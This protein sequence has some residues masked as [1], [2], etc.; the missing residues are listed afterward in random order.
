MA[1][2]Q[3]T[4]LQARW[5]DR[6]LA[7]ALYRLLWLA[8]RL[9]LRALHTLGAGI[10]WLMLR[11]DSRECRVA[12][13]N[14][15]L[16]FPTLP[17]A[18][19]DELLSATL[20]QTGCTITE[21]ARLWTR[22]SRSN[23]ALVQEVRNPEL[24]DAALA[25]GKGLIIAA[26]HQG[27]W[28]LLNQYLASRMPLS[29]VYRPP[30]SAAVELLLR[31]VRG[32]EGVTQ[33]RAHGAGVR[34][35]FRTLCDGG[36]LGILPDQQPKLGDGEFAPFFGVP[37]LTMTL[38]PRLAE[39]SGAVV[40]FAHAERLPAAAGF[41][42]VFRESDPALT[43]SD[44]VAAVAALNRGVEACVRDQPTQYQWGYKRFSI[45]PPGTGGSPYR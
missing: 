39:R 36:R 14:F 44:P 4:P 15:E 45:R 43:G 21:T 25:S 42:I 27:N 12:R 8:G 20:R 10:G 1:Q 33:V 28:E 31:R 6:L 5:T 2:R 3:Q 35:L 24:L 26:P 17:N 34:A 13:R 9:P 32:H 30:R 11:F 38:L 41:R 22:T 29:I 40:L 7:L 37:A 23:L 19:R 16:C 18:E